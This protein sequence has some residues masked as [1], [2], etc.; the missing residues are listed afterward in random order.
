MPRQNIRV[1][2]LCS[3]SSQTNYQINLF[4]RRW[5]RSVPSATEPNC[6]ISSLMKTYQSTL[7]CS[8]ALFRTEQSHIVYTLQRAL[9]YNRQ[10]FVNNTQYSVFNSQYSALSISKTNICFCILTIY[11]ITNVICTLERETETDSGAR[12]KIPAVKVKTKLTK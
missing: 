7:A 2:V 11:T 10:Y 6:I 5:S 8:Y 9:Y 4:S 12:L 3:L 1:S